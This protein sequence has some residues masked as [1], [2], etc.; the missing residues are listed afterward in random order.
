[1]SAWADI[2]FDEA[3]FEDYDQEIEKR[4]HP[5]NYEDQFEIEEEDHE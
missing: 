1:M 5:E 2:Y 4:Y 3:A